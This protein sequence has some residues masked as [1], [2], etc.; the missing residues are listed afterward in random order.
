MFWVTANLSSRADLSMSAYISCDRCD[1]HAGEVIDGK[2]T[3]ERPL[4]EGTF[5]KV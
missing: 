3:V 5:G 2:Y 1:F 4:G